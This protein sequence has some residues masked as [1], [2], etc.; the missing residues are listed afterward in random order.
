MDL[1]I[2]HQKEQRV[3]AADAAAA[4]YYLLNSEF[5]VIG[6]HTCEENAENAAVGTSF[7]DLFPARRA[8]REE[9]AAYV[10]SYPQ[11]VLLTLCGR[12]P[13]VFVGMLAAHTGLVLALMPQGEVKSTLSFPAAFHHVPAC[14]SVSPSAQMRYKAHEE[15]VFAAACRWLLSVSAPFTY[16]KGADRALVPALSFCAARLCTLLNVPFSYDFSGLP[17]LHCEGLELD[18]AIGVMLAAL[19]AARGAGAADGVRLYAAMEGAPTLYLEYVRTEIVETV[20]EFLPVLACAE[21]RGVLLDVVCP[22]EDPHCVQVRACFGIAELSA[23]G[24][25]ERHRFL[26]G[27]S[28]LCTLSQRRAIPASFPELLPD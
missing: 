24:V 8:V 13:V 27:K 20:S 1:M 12:T 3:D 22:R 28:P 14:V 26:E 6:A 18:F 11:T 21:A 2:N 5:C 9:I 19:A 17:A 4:R 10:Q 7:F 23:Q 15:A 16:T 25:R